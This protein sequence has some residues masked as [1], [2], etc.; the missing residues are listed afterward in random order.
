MA[1][2]QSSRFSLPRIRSTY[3]RGALVAIASSKLLLS[4]SRTSCNP[5]IAGTPL[6]N[7]CS[8]ID[9]RICNSWSGASTR[10]SSSANTRMDWMGDR[11]IIRPKVSSL[12]VRAKC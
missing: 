11:P 12:T 1:L 10:P 4:R 8:A 7:D 5:G 3:A 2:K 6:R 9:S